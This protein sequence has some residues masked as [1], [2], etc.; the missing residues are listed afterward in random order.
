[1]VGE[2]GDVD[3]LVGRY[4][5]VNVKLDK[6]GGLTAALDLVDAAR[7]AGLQLMIGSMVCTSLAVAPAML[8][9][10]GAAFV[11]LDGPLLL[12]VDRDGGLELKDHRLQP[13]ARELWG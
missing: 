6:T 11:D 2:G 4:D 3:G 8:L 9:C 13:P 1:M 5:V 7:A 12:A 10:A